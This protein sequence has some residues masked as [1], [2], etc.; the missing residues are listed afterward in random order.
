VGGGGGGRMTVHAH[1]TL[2]Y[3]LL[4]PGGKKWDEH[5]AV[6]GKKNSMQHGW[7]T[8][9][10]KSQGRLRRKW[11]VILK[12]HDNYSGRYEMKFGM[13]NIN[14]RLHFKSH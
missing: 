4:K 3:T 8:P 12:D 13:T 14:S 2:F 1:P 7:K 6:L 11:R 10:N 9:G 5:V